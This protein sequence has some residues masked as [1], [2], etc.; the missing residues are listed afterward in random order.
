MEMG[1]P[2]F[3]LAGPVSEDGPV[4]GDGALIVPVPL[5][6]TRRFQVFCWLNGRDGSGGEPLRRFGRSLQA[7]GELEGEKQDAQSQ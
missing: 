4:C 3:L 7:K 5:M 6:D 1:F 2:H